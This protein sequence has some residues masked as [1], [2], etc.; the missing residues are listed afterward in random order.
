[1]QLSI[2]TADPRPIHVQIV[3]EVRR[4]VVLGTLAAG[5]VLPPVRHMAAELRVNPASVAEAYRALEGEGLVAMRWG[6]G[7]VVADRAAEPGDRDALVRQVA[8]RALRD[9]R[10]H[11]IGAAELAEAIRA[12]A[13]PSPA[14][15]ALPGDAIRASASPRVMA[16]PASPALLESPASPVQP[17][18]PAR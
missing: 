13:S 10:R 2:D 4:A 12:A 7:P 3:D 9:A 16:S 11:G 15:P 8:E 17:G 1:M 18:A 14:S 5:D 6:R